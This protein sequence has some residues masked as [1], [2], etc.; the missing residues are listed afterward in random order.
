MQNLFSFI[1][2]IPFN[3]ADELKRPVHLS[4]VETRYNQRIWSKVT[5]CCDGAI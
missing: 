2:F 3:K 4:N 5:N 1:L